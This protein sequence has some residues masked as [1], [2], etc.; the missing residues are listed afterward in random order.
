LECILCNSLKAT[1]K[2]STKLCRSFCHEDCK[3]GEKQGTVC[4]NRRAPKPSSFP[5]RYLI[6]Y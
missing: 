5:P 1:S 2:H 4:I 6:I 3:I